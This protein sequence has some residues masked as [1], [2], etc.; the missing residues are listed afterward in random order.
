MSFLNTAILKKLDLKTAKLL[1]LL[2]VLAGCAHGK[3]ISNHVGQTESLCIDGLIANMEDGKCTS[4]YV[5]GDPTIEP[6]RIRCTQHKEETIW[7]SSRFYVFSNTG[8]ESID[9]SRLMPVCQDGLT[10]LF[11]EI[12]K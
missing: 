8:Y 9:T 2:S 7:T 12:S 11:I 10:T 3:K 1:V 5:G 4:V 6:I